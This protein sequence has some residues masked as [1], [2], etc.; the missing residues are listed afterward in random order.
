MLVKFHLFNTLMRVWKGKT[1]A[2]TSSSGKFLSGKQSS[3]ESVS[4]FQIY[5]FGEAVVVVVVGRTLSSR[6]HGG[7]FLILTFGLLNALR[8]AVCS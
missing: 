7:C 6:I 4:I 2:E 5:G 8:V 1:I 3:E